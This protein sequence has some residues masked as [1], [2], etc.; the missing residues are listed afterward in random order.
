MAGAS[1]T[2]E[3]AAMAEER[4]QVVAVRDATAPRRGS[5]PYEAIV[6]KIATDRAVILDGAT[7]TELFEVEG[8]RPEVD[9]HMWGVAAINEADRKSVV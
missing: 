9:D 7:G 4:T 5:E 6:R 1:G 3:T 8:R 2:A